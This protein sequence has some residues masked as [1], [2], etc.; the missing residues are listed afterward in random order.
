[1]DTIEQKKKVT[2]KDLAKIVGVTPRTVSLAVRGEG[3]M[4]KETRHKIL[5]LCRK[6]NYRP[7]IMG[8]GLAEGKTFLVGVLIPHI[9]MS[10]YADV[11][12]GI[13]TR[14]SE[15]SYDALIR[16]SEHQLD[17]E[18]EAVERF[19]ERRV[20]GI[21]CYPDAMAGGVYDRVMKLGIPLIQIGD[22]IPG[23]KASSVVTDNIH[24]GFLATEKLIKCN[25]R[26]I[27]FVGWNDC[28][29]VRDRKSGYHKA[30][31]RY[32]IQTDLSRSEVV[33]YDLNQGEEAGVE[34]LKKFGEVD[35]IVCVSDEMAIGVV[36]SMLKAGK[37]IPDDVCIIG[38]DDLKIADCQIGIQLSTI[39]QPKLELGAKAFDLLLKSIKGE[40][41]ESLV[42]EPHYIGRGTTRQ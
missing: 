13:I 3:R 19:I 11:I 4:S 1:M 39:V 42:L 16:V 10:F 27:A 28:S 25:C 34:L 6:L 22:V 33:G 12:K 21:I 31:I 38:Y 14:C 5:E 30:L 36:R 23:L 9:G 2:L 17:N 8:R 15:N 24:G 32:G 37:R 35:G 29:V 7:D 18:I 26:N 41:A 40:K 20:D